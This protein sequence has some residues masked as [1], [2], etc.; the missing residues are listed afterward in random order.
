VG[1]PRSKLKQFEAELLAG[2]LGAVR[3][4]G[5]VKRVPMPGGE[6]TYVLCRTTA[7]REKEKAIRS[8]FSA[9]IEKALGQLAQ[10]VA[11]GQL[12]DRG[13]IKRRSGRIEAR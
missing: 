4:D 11:T 2:G 7:R 12:K 8:R 13:K 9:Q 5:E 6:E 10:R 1:T 3:H